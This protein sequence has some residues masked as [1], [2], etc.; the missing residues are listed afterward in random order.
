MPAPEF[1]RAAWERGE[2]DA[3]WYCIECYTDYWD[4]SEKEVMESLGFSKRQSKKDQ[5]MRACAASASTDP[6]NTPKPN[7]LKRK[8]AFISDTRFAK[9][10]KLRKT[11]CGQCDDLFGGNE[12]GA[13]W[14]RENMP[15]PGER[16]TAWE[17]GDWDATW[18]CIGCYMRYYNCTREAIVDML[19]FT[20]RAAKKACYADRKA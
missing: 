16:K 14:H 18:Y 5:F 11:R 20:A 7:H 6:S 1:R 9:E 13:F 4:C 8:P 2:W 19:G 15:P 3:S 12:A 17:S 10:R